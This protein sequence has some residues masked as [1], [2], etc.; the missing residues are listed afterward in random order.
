MRRVRFLFGAEEPLA[1][2]RTP[3][4][5]HAHLLKLLDCER[6]GFQ[7]SCFLYFVKVDVGVEQRLG[8]PSL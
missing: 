5:R 3:P 4:L 6:L 7:F 2:K 8:T 1:R